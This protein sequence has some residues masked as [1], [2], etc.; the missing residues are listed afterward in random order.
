MATPLA[1]LLPQ[2]VL[3]FTDFDGNPLAG[4]SVS[5]FQPNTTTLKTVW[6]DPQESVALQNP[7][8]LDG[9]GRPETGSSEVEVYGS[10]QYS[11][12]VK[13]SSGNTIYGPVLT[14]D[15]I[16]LINVVVG[17]GSGFILASQQGAVGD[18]TTDD[19]QAIQTTINMAAL[20]GK[21]AFLVGTSGSQFKITS[22]LLVTSPQAYI[23]GSGQGVTGLI[24]GGNFSAI[25]QVANTTIQGEISGIYF[26]QTGTTTQC[27]N[28]AVATS[29]ERPL[30]FTE[31]G[32]IG[33]Y[34]QTVGGT[35][36]YC[37]GVLIQFLRCFFNPNFASL[38]ALQIDMNNENTSI[39]GCVFLGVGY[40]IDLTN[41]LN[42][43][44]PQGVRIQDCLLANFGAAYNI[45]I[46]GNAAN[47]YI[48]GTVCDQAGTNAILIDGG[49]GAIQISD[50]W[51]GLAAAAAGQ[52]IAVDPTVQ[53]LSIQ[54]MQIFGGTIN[55]L[56]EANPT[57]RMGGL[58][59]QN[60]QFS[61]T[62]NTLGS[63]Q[64]DSVNGCTIT[65][66]RD[67]NGSQCSSLV[68]L[69]TN[70]AG[71]QY[72]IGANAFTTKTP[73]LDAASSYVSSGKCTGW[74]LEGEG[75]GVSTS[76]TNC[77]IN[78]NLNCGLVP[79]VA[80]AS[81]FGTSL[82][83]F[84]VTTKTTTQINIGYFITGAAGGA[85]AA[86]FSYRVSVAR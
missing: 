71:G 18:G 6:A 61:G 86:E 66:N 14:Q 39:L 31:C 45:H 53:E 30:N 32:F 48:S 5:Y 11:M 28:I 12:V 73:T 81:P 27:L 80:L 58:Q 49:S 55:L 35:L 43:I 24:A 9:A 79:D 19:T 63:M 10:G 7:V 33:D 60:N 56:V 59:I 29:G 25:M 41:T 69:R 84:T 85:G 42:L 16:A 8:T 67:F 50:G 72:I 17:S 26:N 52:A 64:L 68:T 70:A 44:G 75:I 74:S 47:V 36:V 46:G 21:I 2:G 54:N 82:L 3:Q 23:Q 57:Q 20:A 15:Y 78:H 65:G 1:S 37:G 34:N 83:T 51:A 77:T 40:G 22:P 4:G 13:D 76:G 62:A 38:L